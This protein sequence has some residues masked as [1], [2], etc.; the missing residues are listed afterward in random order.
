MR[1]S[2]LIP[3]STASDVEIAGLASDS[4]DVRPGY[5][6]AALPGT[7][8]SGVD[9]IA[10][11]VDRG[12]IAVLAPD[13]T[14]PDLARGASLVTDPNPRRRLGAR[15]CPLLRGCSLRSWPASPEPTAR[16]R[17]PTLPARSGELPARRRRPSGPSA[18]VWT[19]GDVLCGTRRPTPSPCT[20]CWPSFPQTGSTIW[21]WR[22]RATGSR[23][24]VWTACGRRRRRSRPSP[25][26]TWITTPT[27]TP[28]SRPKHAFLSRSWRRK[29]P[30]CSTPTTS[31][32]RASLTAVGARGQQ[33]LTYGAAGADLRLLDRRDTQAGQDLSVAILGAQHEIALPLPGAFQAHNALAA[34]G[35]ALATGVD[36]TEAVHALR[37]LDCV[38]G[39]LQRIAGHPAG[40]DVFVDYAHTPDAL[41]SAL[42]AVR[43]L[44]PCTLV[45]VF[46]CGGE[47][48]VGKRR[49]MGAVAAQLAD[50]VI[51]TDDNPRREDPALIRRAILDRLSRC[52]WR[53]A[54]AAGP[55]AA[56]SRRWARETVCSSPARAMSG[57]RSWPTAQSRSTMPTSRGRP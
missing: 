41:A 16:P 42:R 23:S 9:F 54:T 32:S 8:A 53:S 17:W 2:E 46:G 5:L 25:V 34:L 19:V 31:G 48:D 45:V 30:Q 33:V 47:R 55:F 13:G 36:A 27:P 22:R 11:A 44:V 49:E 51:V 56:P 50:R 43:P 12:A 1:L 18:P 35:V 6:F 28:T 10:D 20:A 24:T 15:G 40:A 3:R 4:R 37:A 26:I 29:A 38:P 52:G 21:R 7:R 57:S 39:R 14:A